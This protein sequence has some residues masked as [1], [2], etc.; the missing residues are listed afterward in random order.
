MLPRRMR[1]RRSSS[2]AKV[3]DE[4][5]GQ[6]HRDVPVRAVRRT[7]PSQPWDRHGA[8]R[9]IG[10]PR[11]HPRLLRHVGRHRA[12]QRSGTRHVSRRRRLASRTVHDPRVEIRSGRTRRAIISTCGDARSRTALGANLAASLERARL[13]RNRGSVR[14]DRALP[15]PPISRSGA[16]ERIRRACVRRGSVSPA[17]I[18]RAGR[19]RR[20]RRRRVALTS[21]AQERPR[22]EPY[23]GLSPPLRRRRAR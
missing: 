7:W 3:T 1:G 22:R 13:R 16:R 9:S 8:C 12:R 10:R 21:P 11:P 19:R 23:R 2:R 4:P 14:G 20:S 5:P 15:V 6:R 17:S 18:R